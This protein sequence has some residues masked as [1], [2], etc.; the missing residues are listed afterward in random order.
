[1]VRLRK[2]LNIGEKYDLWPVIDFI[3]VSDFFWLLVRFSYQ[4]TFL[5]AVQPGII[6]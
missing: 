2:K 4:V 6:G 1:M 3:D 5:E